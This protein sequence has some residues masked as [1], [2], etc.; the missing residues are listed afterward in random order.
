MPAALLLALA[1][2]VGALSSSGGCSSE[3]ARHPFTSDDLAKAR[4]DS[5]LRSLSVVSGKVGEQLAPLFP[6]FLENFNP[7][8]ARF[9]GSPIDFIVFDG[10]DGG[11]VRKVVL[12]EV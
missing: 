2:R 12:I 11:E 1:L 7:K 8:D 6:E 9:L 4:K 10:L 3:R 5:I